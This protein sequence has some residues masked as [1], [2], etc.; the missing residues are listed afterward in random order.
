MVKKVEY[1]A[2]EEFVRN[3]GFKEKTVKKN[4]KRRPGIE[5]TDGQST[6]I[7]GTRYP[8]NLRGTKIN[9]YISK[10]LA[11]MKAINKNQYISHKELH[12]EEKQFQDMLESLYSEN[13]I[14]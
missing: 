3:C 10:S 11:L 6:V 7:S 5:K 8:Y 9:D 12:M 4:Y 13:L 2:F 1:I 14:Q